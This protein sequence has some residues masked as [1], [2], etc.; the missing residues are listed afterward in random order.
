[1][2][3]KHLLDTSVL[4][5][6]HRAQVQERIIE[7]SPGGEA[8]RS[9]MSDLEVGCSAASPA[10]WDQLAEMIDPF[11]AVEIQAVDFH[12]ALQTQRALAL[13]GLKGRK[14][15][16]LLIASCAERLGLNVLHYDRDFDHIAMVTGQSTEWIVPRG[17]ID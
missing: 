9:A 14:V 10:D 16:D 12:R 17:S 8:G 3:L 2:A 4:T 11:P 5:R 7:V 6:L 15:A 1:M 13:A